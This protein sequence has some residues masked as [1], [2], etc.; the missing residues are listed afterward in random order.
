MITQKCA[1]SLAANAL[2]ML[3][4]F[5]ALYVCELVSENK[6]LGLALAAALMLL[7]INLTLLA[8]Y[9][10]VYGIIAF[11]L[12]SKSTVSSYYHKSIFHS[13]LHTHF[14]HEKI[15]IP[16][17]I[18]RNDYGFAFRKFIYVIVCIIHAV[19][20]PNMGVVFPV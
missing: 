7:G 9:H 15:K 13:V 18:S 5:V 3:I 6:Y 16:V 8:K 12:K 4:S 11:V 2:F 17:N 14:I 20:F 1:V 19:C 10:I